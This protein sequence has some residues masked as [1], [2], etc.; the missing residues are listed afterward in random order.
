MDL[1]LILMTVKTV[2]K[3]DATEGIAEGQV[4]AQK[5]VADQDP[6]SVEE[7]VKEIVKK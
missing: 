2:L 6:E 7:I 3:K 1:K 4:T 5:D